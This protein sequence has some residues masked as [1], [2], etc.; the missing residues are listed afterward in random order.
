VT[1]AA[2]AHQVQILKSL[3]II[4]MD[5]IVYMFVEILKSQRIMVIDYIV[6]IFV[7]FLKSQRC[8]YC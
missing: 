1:Y 7:E 8:S 4:V 2:A 3:C 6:Y 5:Y